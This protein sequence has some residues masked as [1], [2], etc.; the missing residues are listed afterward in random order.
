MRTSKLIL[1]GISTAAALAFATPAAATDTTV[2]ASACGAGS[3]TDSNTATGCVFNGNINESTNW[4]HVAASYINAQNAYN[5][6][7]SPDI[8]LDLLDSSLVSFTVN[9]DGMTGTFTADPGFVV[10][11]IAIKAADMF[12]IY[13]LYGAGSGT[14]STAD[15][16]NNGGQT[17]DLS[18]LLFFGSVG[19]GVPEPATWAMMLVGVGMI[20]S[21]MRRR[22]RKQARPTVLA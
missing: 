8:T 19:P 20:G 9:G 22:N 10:D 5:D 11:Y 13:D 6:Y 21:S 17:P 18:H 7:T 12:I 15:L 3:L 1:A 14:W 16:V 2:V 4:T